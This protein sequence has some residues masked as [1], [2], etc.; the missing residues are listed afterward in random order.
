MKR[1]VIVLFLFLILIILAD[2]VRAFG[3][4]TPYLENNTLKVLPGQN[5]TYTLTLQNGDEEDY[6]VD[7]IYS[8]TNNVA[9]MISETYY[10]PAKTYNNTFNFNINIPSNAKIGEKYVLEYSAKPRTSGNGTVTLGVEIKRSVNILVTDEKNTNVEPIVSPLET[11]KQVKYNKIF[12]GAWKYILLILILALVFFLIVRLWKLSRGI[13]LK[14]NRKLQT[15]HTISQ[16]ISLVEVKI[17]LQKISDEEF[18]LP[19]IRKLFKSKL[20]ELTNN[21]I[22]EEIPHISRREAIIA[23]D[24]ILK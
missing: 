1:G 19:E 20:S 4:S 13:S 21:E 17:L 7:I 10:T 3:I 16:A 6:Y 9:N 14:L 23:L 24:H 2:T 11:L 15:D 22:V 5:Y 18:E 8:S 12:L